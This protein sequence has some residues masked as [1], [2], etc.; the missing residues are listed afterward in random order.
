MKQVR[1]RRAMALKNPRRQMVRSV[2][3]SILGMVAA[4]MASACMAFPGGSGKAAPQA[5]A[6]VSNALAW[7]DD[8]PLQTKD[9]SQA[10]QQ[11]LTDLE[12]DLAQR[13][14]H[15]LWAGVEDSIADWLL[16]QEA[17]RRGLTVEALL[18]AEVVSKVGSPHD[19]ELRDLYD[20]NRATI[21]VPFAQA[22]SE[23]RSAWQQDRVKQLRRAL[24]DGLRKDHNVRYNLPPP[25]LQ[26]YAV[27]ANDGPARGPQQ[28]PVT[29]IEFG[30][31]ECPYCA[32]THRLLQRISALYPKD[33]R[34][35]YRD[36]P[37]SQHQHARL[38][39]QAGQCAEEQNKFW[40]YHDLLFEHNNALE[41]ADLQHY[42]EAAELNVDAFTQCLASERPQQ[43]V[44]AS[45]AAA[46][47]AGVH[48]TPVLFV[49]G[50]RLRGVLPLPLMQAIIDRELNH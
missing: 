30:D 15:L 33:V 3:R 29:I 5:A 11:R 37:L 34:V 23:L 49:N 26:R 21:G 28:A 43:K 38:A 45:V 2:Y 18:E 31:F 40:P 41:R 4:Q 13:R 48:S 32:Q 10:T 46:Q 16:Q 44:T 1:I 20:N 36:F 47:A 24:I 27:A 8:T 19:V 6:P 12:S 14:Y 17:R 35:I 25:V 22:A 50:L 39:A 42:A 7:I 9:L